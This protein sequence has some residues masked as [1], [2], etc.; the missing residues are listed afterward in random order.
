MA[1]GGR[2]GLDIFKTKISWNQ[3]TVTRICL[4]LSASSQSSRLVCNS[5][6]LQAE[7]ELFWNHKPFCK[8]PV[9]WD[10]DCKHTCIYTPTHPHPLLSRINHK[11]KGKSE[12]IQKR[13]E[14]K[15]IKVAHCE[16]LTRMQTAPDWAHSL[17]RLVCHHH[18]HHHQAESN[19]TV[20]W[21]L[22]ETHKIIT[23]MGK[24]TVCCV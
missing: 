17:D 21:R 14:E 9:C 1:V 5:E 16:R 22:I 4:D 11:C 2:F 12:K 20:G 8:N 3:L 24:M 7:P 19:G 15:K 23:E 6:D 10:A 18:H 13:A